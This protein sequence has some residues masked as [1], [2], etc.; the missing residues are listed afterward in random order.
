MEEKL[1]ALTSKKTFEN[2]IVFENV[3]FA[4]PEESEDELSLE[5]TDETAESNFVFFEF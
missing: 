3:S 2:E 4:S 1:I 5:E